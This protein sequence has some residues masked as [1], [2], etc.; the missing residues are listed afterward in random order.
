MK[1]GFNIGSGPRPFFTNSEVEW[2]NVDKVLHPAMPV[3]DLLSDGADLPHPDGAADYVVLHHVL[4]HFGCGEAAGL[5]REAHRVL[6]PN[7]SLLVFVPDLRALAERWLVKGL[8]TQIYVTSLYGAYMGHEED[9][10]KWGFDFG[11]L[12]EFLTQNASW[13]TVLPFD[14]RPIS[15]ADLARDWWI[16]GVECVR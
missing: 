9:R 10:H 6:K 11:S 15:G 14:W 8:S 3:P 2:I 4:E 16:L 1:L 12:H 7:G 13:T 5:V